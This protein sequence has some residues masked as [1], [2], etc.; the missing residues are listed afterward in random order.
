MMVRQIGCERFPELWFL[1]WD[2]IRIRLKK[3]VP[4]MRL[5]NF[6]LQLFS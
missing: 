4:F 5:R 6:N 1:I 2:R 3:F